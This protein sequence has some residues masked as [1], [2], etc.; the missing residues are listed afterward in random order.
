MRQRRV[1]KKLRSVE[2]LQR[3]QI[4][5]ILLAAFIVWALL[6]IDHIGTGRRSGLVVA[7][8]G[9]VVAL[10]L[11]RVLGVIFVALTVWSIWF[12]RTQ[13]RQLKRQLERRHNVD[14]SIRQDV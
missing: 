3:H 5:F 4:K 12:E 11:F 14:K 2:A 10:W 13:D 9:P 6:V 7:L 1:W 8:F